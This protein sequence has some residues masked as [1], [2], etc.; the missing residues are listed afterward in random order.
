MRFQADHY[1]HLQNTKNF[2]NEAISILLFE[3]SINCTQYFTI[4]REIE[5]FQVSVDRW[6]FWDVES[7]Y[8]E[9]MI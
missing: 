5:N 9:C 3:V 1:V 7:Q 4:V 6:Q 8:L 2:N